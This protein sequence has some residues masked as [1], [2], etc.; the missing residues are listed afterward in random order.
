MSQT[1]KRHDT[2]YEMPRVNEVESKS[3]SRRNSGSGRYE[4]SMEVMRVASEI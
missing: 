1:A 4:R 3:K 2:V